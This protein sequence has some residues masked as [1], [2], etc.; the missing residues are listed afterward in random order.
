M[1]LSSIDI[2]RQ[3]FHKSFISFS[4]YKPND[5]H[6][7]LESVAKEVDTY[8]EKLRSSYEQI[9]RLK[10]D[11]DHYQKVEEALQEALQTA[12]ENA[13]KTQQNAEQKA[14]LILQDSESRSVR[15]IEEASVQAQ[16]IVH[17]AEVMKSQARLEVAKLNEKRNE[18]TARLRA[19]LSSEME[20]LGK[21]E[22]SQM[23]MLPMDAR[24]LTSSFSFPTETVSLPQENV[25]PTSD[26]SISEDIEMKTDSFSAV[27]NADLPPEMEAEAPVLAA[28]LTEMPV[29]ID[30]A[31]EMMEA[32]LDEEM[33]LVLGDPIINMMEEA[34]EMVVETTLPRMKILP[35]TQSAAHFFNE[36]PVASSTTVEPIAQKEYQPIP[37]TT[38]TLTEAERIQR[39]LDELQ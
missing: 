17:E 37:V 11:L 35:E 2:R 15:M 32:P 13:R 33:P 10:N 4:S 20:L 3:E 19:Y 21:I 29:T 36:K 26:G 30:E 31:Q 16:K 7:F 18:L 22:N 27:M 38:S 25:F 23:Q 12:R 5:V 28:A 14:A 1:A 39:I 24:P 8:N 9:Q 6:D 34:P